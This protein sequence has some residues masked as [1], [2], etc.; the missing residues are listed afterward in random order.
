QNLG[1][2]LA[3]LGHP[4]AAVGAFA[5]AVIGGLMHDLLARQMVRQRLA[6]RLAA[7]ADRSHRFG[8][9]GLSFGF[10]GGFGL[11]GFQFL[12]PQFELLDLA[13]DALRRAAKLHAAQLG[14]LQLE[15]LDLQRLVLHRELRYLKLALAGQGEGAQRDHLGGQFGGGE[16][17]ARSIFG[18][19]LVN[20]S[21]IRIGALSDQHWSARR[22]QRYRAAP[23]HRLDQHR[24]LRGCQRH[25]AIDD[26]RPDETT[27]PDHLLDLRSKAVEPGAQIDRLAGEEDLRP[28]RQADHVAPFIARS[29]RDSAFSFTKA[30]TLTRAPFGSTIS[31]PPT[32]LSL[33]PMGRGGSDLGGSGSGCAS[34]AVSRWPDPPNTPSGMNGTATGGCITEAAAF[35]AARQ[36][37]STLAEIR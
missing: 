25:R 23:V 9:I 18:H 17:H 33:A 32:P 11:A 13:G 16:R 29:T 24:H 37:Y 12:K 20:H 31:I 35:H 21:K 1:H 22:R 6:L 14:D 26:R 8:G 28:R 30:S 2:V 15:L 7:L 27:L 36:L 10:R 5:G 19:I 34:I 3:E 4:L